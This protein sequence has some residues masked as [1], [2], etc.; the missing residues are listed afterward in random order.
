M[1][2]AM[3]NSDN[4]N[5]AMSAQEINQDSLLALPNVLGV[6]TGFRERK[7]KVTNEIAVH[8]FVA[9]KLPV[10]RLAS[11]E[12]VP[13]KI[14]GARGEPVATDVVQLDLPYAQ[15]DRTRYRPVPGGC[16]IGPEASNSAGTLGGWACDHTDDTIVLLSN[17]HVISNLDTMPVLR[18]IVQPGRFDG[19]VLPGDVIGQLKRHIAVTTVANVAGAPVPAVSAV[20]AAIGTITV[21]R[22]DNVL[23]I[24]P[25]IYEIQAPVVGMNVQ[26]RGRTTRLTTNGSI[27]SINITTNITYRNRT[28][29]GRVGNAFVIRSTD[30]NLFSNAGDSGSL[31]FNQQAG[32]LEGTFPVVG[33][34]F[35][36]ATFN[37]GTPATIANDI[38]AVFG[39]LNLE[40]VCNC[41][42][43][44]LIEAVFGS[45]QVMEA[46]GSAARP[47]VRKERQLRQFRTKVLRA[48]AFGKAVDKLLTTR[49]AQLA[50]VI[51]ED[52][53]AFGLAVKMLEP[54]IRHRTNYEVL[55]AKIDAQTVENFG[56][57]ADRA[58]KVNRNLRNELLMVKYAMTAVEG[59]K[60]RSVLRS[61]KLGKPPTKG[62]G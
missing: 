42:A 56:R 3:A 8:I 48:T 44:A 16:S 38:N 46:G 41:V 60:V 59:K 32:E 43:R 22:T 25:A 31:I 26:K 29:L 57:F 30:G 35:G 36:G 15:Q 1:E 58:G 39:A 18:R 5:R 51:V 2:E 49:T 19:G 62:K 9:K 6:G 11:W 61:A 40:T 53:D 12:T 47:L 24:G 17:N 7:G 37:D 20:D 50:Q 54:W 28:R 14:P 45:S 27:F 23:Q 21:D 52:E 55:E 10:D 4:V 33:L 34:L 13:R